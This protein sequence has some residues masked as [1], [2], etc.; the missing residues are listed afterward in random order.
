MLQPKVWARCVRSLA[1]VYRCAATSTPPHCPF[2]ASSPQ[3]P[4]HLA[5]HSHTHTPFLPLSFARART[6]VWYPV[7][8]CHIQL[9]PARHGPC[10]HGQDLEEEDQVE[11][12]HAAPLLRLGLLKHALWLQHR[13]AV[14]ESPPARWHIALLHCR[15]NRHVRPAAR[16]LLGP[17][18][19]WEE[20]EGE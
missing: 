5:A 12:S 8:I 10:D 11:E 2:L 1:Q 14:H 20:G 9:H 18:H 19:V 17:E 13:R 6:H 7:E 3:S 16:P 4:P 15:F